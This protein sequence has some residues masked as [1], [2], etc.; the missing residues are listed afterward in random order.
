MDVIFNVQIAVDDVVL[1]ISICCDNGT[2]SD[3]L[4]TVDDFNIRLTG[5]TPQLNTINPNRFND[6]YIKETFAGLV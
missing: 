4:A 3:V 6:L 2:K 1:I 5:T